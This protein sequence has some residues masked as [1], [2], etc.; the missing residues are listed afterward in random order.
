MSGRSF[1]LTALL[2]AAP[3]AGHAADETTRGPAGA[4]AFLEHVYQTLDQTP[5]LSEALIYDAALRRL[6]DEDARLN[7]GFLGALEADPLCQCQDTDHFL[8]MVKVARWKTTTAIAHVQ[9]ENGSTREELTINLVYEQ[10]H[11]RIDD[12][13]PPSGPTMRKALEKSNKRIHRERR[14]KD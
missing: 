4:Q 13:V 3:A 2:L 5:P 14:L 11:W 7:E 9:V 6:L 10:G 12:I 8:A 1:V